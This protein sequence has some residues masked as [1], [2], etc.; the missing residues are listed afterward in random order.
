MRQLCLSPSTRSAAPTGPKAREG[1]G[2]IIKPWLAPPLIT[3]I[4][5]IGNI[6]Y[7]I[8]NG[9]DSTALMTNTA[10]TIITAVLAGTALT[11]L[12]RDGGDKAT[13]TFIIR[14]PPC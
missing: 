11:R 10:L 12:A 9:G 2:W 8:I 3:T 13:D 7:R 4:L 14:G 6:Q 5:A 1:A